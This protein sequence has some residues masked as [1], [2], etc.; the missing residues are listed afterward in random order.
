MG[1]KQYSARDPNW[2]FRDD[3]S[4]KQG[5]SPDPPGQPSLLLAVAGAAHAEPERS[6]GPGTALGGCM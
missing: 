3:N 4:I 2:G 6:G 5:M 1:D